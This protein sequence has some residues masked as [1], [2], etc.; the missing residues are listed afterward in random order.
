M[1]TLIKSK[2]FV[3][4]EVMSIYGKS[5]DTKPTHEFQGERIVNGSTFYEMDTKNAFMY[6]EETHTWLAQ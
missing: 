2:H 3:N 4:E 6:D 5:T 1:V